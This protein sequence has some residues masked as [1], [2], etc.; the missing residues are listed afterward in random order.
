MN[1][2]DLVRRCTQLEETPQ[3]KLSGTAGTGGP[4]WNDKCNGEEQ[5]NEGAA[6]KGCAAPGVVK[7]VFVF[8]S[9]SSLKLKSKAINPPILHF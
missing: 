3:K 6:H 7:L 8:L 9:R 5:M 1:P 2:C 4:T